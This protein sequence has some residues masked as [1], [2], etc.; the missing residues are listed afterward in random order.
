MRCATRMTET[1]GVVF[2]SLTRRFRITHL[3]ST[4]PRTTVPAANVS[5]SPPRAEHQP[6][7]ATAP[8][9]PPG[10]TAGR[11]PAH[12]AAQTGATLPSCRTDQ[13]TGVP[14]PIAPDH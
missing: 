6:P 2:L 7:P 5:R 10:R 9:P 12:H 8:S 13:T 3:T 11:T 1:I 4:A 14:T